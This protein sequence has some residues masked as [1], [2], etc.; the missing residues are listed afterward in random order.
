MTSNLTYT[1]ETNFDPIYV[2]FTDNVVCYP[3][4]KKYMYLVTDENSL[5]HLDK[6]SIW[7]IADGELASIVRSIDIQFIQHRSSN[8]E[9]YLKLTDTVAPSLRL[10]PSGEYNILKVNVR[11]NN[12]NIR[13]FCKVVDKGYMPIQ[14]VDEEDG[15]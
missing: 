7:L 15:K 3:D 10:A 5:L 14:L 11:N 1:K 8:L 13:A 2:S 12:T 9:A 4:K 6:N